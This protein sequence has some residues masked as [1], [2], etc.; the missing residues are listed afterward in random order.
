MAK[1]NDIFYFKNNTETLEINFQKNEND[2]FKSILKLNSND[3]I[4]IT[5]PNNYKNWEPVEILNNLPVTL[6][7]GFV[8]NCTIHILNS[9]TGK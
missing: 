3:K 1:T 9:H 8:P 5:P 6:L 4:G 2:T 7:D